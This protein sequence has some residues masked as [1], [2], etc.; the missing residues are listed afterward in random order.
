[1]TNKDLYQTVTNKIIE[2]LQKGAIPWQKPWKGGGHPVNFISKKPYRGINALLLWLDMQERGYTQPYYLTFKQVSNK[3]GKVK[4]GAQSQLVIYWN[5]LHRKTEEIGPDGK[6]KVRKIALL[7][8]YRVFNIEQTEGLKYDSNTQ[9]LTEFQKIEQCE[10]IVSGYATRPQ[11]NHSGLARACYSPS[12]DAVTMPEQRAFISE[13]EYYSTLFHELVHSTGHEKRL[14][15]EELAQHDG[16]GGHNYS[17]EELTAEIGTAFLCTLTGIDNKTLD[18]SQAYINSWIQ[19]L[20]ND[21]KMVVMASARAQRAVDYMLGIK[22]E[23]I[24]ATEKAEEES[25]AVL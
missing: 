7:K 21:E 18:N 19:A 20:R 22:F 3:G 12:R 5:F 24:A 17:K 11:I 16:F 1:M 23:E 8:Y 14:D 4:K 6:P 9:A 25:A 2:G 10:K 13:E 15:R